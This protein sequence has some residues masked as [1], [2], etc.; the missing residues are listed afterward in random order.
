MEESRHEA[1][2]ISNISNPELEEFSEET[3]NQPLLP[4][5]IPITMTEDNSFR[6]K[7]VSDRKSPTWRYRCNANVVPM[8]GTWIGIQGCHWANCC[9]NRILAHINYKQ[10]RGQDHH[11]LIKETM[12]L[13]RS[14]CEG[15]EET[16]TWFR[17]EVESMVEHFVIVEDNNI[18]TL[19]Q[20]T[21]KYCLLRLFLA[22]STPVGVGGLV[23]VGGIAWYR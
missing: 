1:A 15:N 20:T 10:K 14:V 19:M 5:D 8:A 6:P 3:R 13:W 7:D 21:V 17:Q 4:R 16:S 18:L 11:S 23:R 12:D 22:G 2:Q 9:C